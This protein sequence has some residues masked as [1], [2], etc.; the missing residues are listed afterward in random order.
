MRK[1]LS[2]N[3]INA[4]K[5]N[6]KGSL[7]ILRSI[8][9][10]ALFCG[11]YSYAQKSE[12][13]AQVEPATIVLKD[14]AK[15]Y[16]TDEAFNNQINNNAVILKN[17]DIVPKNKNSASNVLEATS[18]KPVILK[19]DFK[20]EVKNSAE[21]KQKEELKKVKK[22]IDQY[23]KRK[24]AFIN[25]FKG[26]PSSEGFFVSVSSGKDSIAPVHNNY[27]FSKIFFVANSYTVKSALDFLHTQKYT[28]YNNK[29]I[30]YCFSEV[31]SVRPPPF[32]R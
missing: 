3:N 10:F 18:S 32:T 5:L 24:K 4:K 30:D 28:F 23:E 14:G 15:I 20:Q 2:Y 16:S 13:P 7:I 11:S 17:A 27:D 6:F 8:L 31:F 12:N 29:S 1:V 25:D 21:K 22:E 26:S 9:L 19:K